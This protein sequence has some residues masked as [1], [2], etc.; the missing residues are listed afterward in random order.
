MKENRYYLYALLDTRKPGVFDYNGLHFNFLYEPFYIGKG[1]GYRYLQH[2]KE[3]IESTHNDFKVRDYMP[4]VPHDEFVDGFWGYTVV[5]ARTIYW[6]R[7]LD[8]FTF[9]EQKK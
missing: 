5:P 3:T 7:K 2:F 8:T 6:W 9:F 1:K 4:A